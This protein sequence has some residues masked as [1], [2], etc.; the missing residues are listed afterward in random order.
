MLEQ[1]GDGGPLWQSL[2][3]RLN[4]LDVSR[5]RATAKSFN[6][7]K[8]YGRHAELFFILLQNMRRETDPK[9][10]GHVNTD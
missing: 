1:I 3:P 7:A 9:E 4:A 2:W 10:P 6:D 5:V 8:K